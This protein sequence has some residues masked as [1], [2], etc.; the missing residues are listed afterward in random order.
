MSNILYHGS[1]WKRNDGILMPGFFHSGE[2]KKWDKTESNKFLYAD[3][4]KDESIRQAIYA[5]IERDFKVV[6]I[7][8]SE[9]KIIIEA[10]DVILPKDILGQT[11]YLYMVPKLSK[12]DWAKVGNEVNGMTTEWKTP[13]A[14]KYSDMHHIKVSQFLRGYEIVTQLVK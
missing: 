12:D 10:H 1:C 8:G 13:C 14:V 9:G 11:V 4:N 3:E 5:L 6:K 7:H 2:L